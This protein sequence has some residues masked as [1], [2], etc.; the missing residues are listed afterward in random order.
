MKG[1]LNSKTFNSQ[2]C[3]IQPRRFLFCQ[4]HSWT[5]GQCSLNSDN[6]SAYQVNQRGPK[7][8]LLNFWHSFH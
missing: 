5:M 3:L 6:L 8:N 1:H 7:L 4:L 2:S